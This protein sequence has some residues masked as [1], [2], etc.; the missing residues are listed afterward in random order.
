MEEVE[1][2]EEVTKIFGPTV[3]GKDITRTCHFRAFCGP[4]ET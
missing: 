1:E 3:D 2:K 4:E